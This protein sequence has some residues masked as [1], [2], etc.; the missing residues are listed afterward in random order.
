MVTGIRLRGRILRAGMHGRSAAASCAIEEF[1]AAVRDLQCR[2]PGSCMQCAAAADIRI[3][4][5]AS[6]RANGT[7]VKVT[8]CM[9]PAFKTQTCSGMDGVAATDAWLQNSRSSAHAPP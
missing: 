8:S 6:A 9:A 7:A 1:P 5:R 4:V 2:H 3:S